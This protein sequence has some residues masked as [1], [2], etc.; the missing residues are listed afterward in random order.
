MAKYRETR[1]KVPNAQSSKL[2]P[3]AQN[4]TETILK[5]KKKNP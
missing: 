4:K 5:V 3:A 1:V 2:K